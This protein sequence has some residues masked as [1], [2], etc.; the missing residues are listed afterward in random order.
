[1]RTIG[2]V[3]AATLA[4]GGAAAQA[5]P[6]VTA[7]GRL[8]F[9][10]DVQLS[11]DGKHFAG[12]QSLGG[13]PAAVIYAI[14]S[15]AEPQVFASDNWTVASV[16]WVKN[17]RVVMFT[18]T[19]KTIPFGEDPN[20]YTWY[21][22]LSLQVGSADWVQLFGR[23]NDSTSANSSTAVI[24]DKD[25]ADPDTIY[26]PLWTR[27]HNDRTDND[28][29]LRH[30][31]GYR[32]YRLS[33]YRV[34]VHTG[35]AKLVSD[36]SLFPSY[37]LTDGQGGI[38]GRVEQTRTPLVD[39]LSLYRDGSFT[40]VRDFDARADAG[41]NV[42]G[43]TFDGKALAVAEVNAAGRDVLGTLDRSSGAS[44]TPLYS[45]PVYD[46][47]F[48]MG[49]DW[50]GRV[51]GAAVMRDRLE[52]VYFDPVHQAVQSAV[53][54]LFPD[55]DAHPISMT[56]DGA[57]A[58]V[59]VES[60]DQPRTYYLYDVA[61]HTTQKLASEYPDLR[62]RDLGQVQ[63]YPYKAR[64]GLEIPAYLTLPPGRAGKNLPLVVMP[65]GGP[66]ARDGV[67]FDWWAQFLANRGYAV[68]QPNFRGSKGYGRAFNAAGFHQWGLKM[69]DDISDGVKRL[70]ADGVVDGK[71]VCIVGASYGGYA[72]LAGA[73]FTPDLYACAVSIAGPSDLARMLRAERSAYGD[74]S[75][76][77]SFWHSRIGD[78]SADAARLDA[79]SPALHADAVRVPVLLMHGKLDTTVPFAQSEEERDALQRAGKRVELVTFE[80]D[81]HYLN[82]AETRIQMLTALEAF[83]K[84]NIGG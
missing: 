11:P 36:G 63:P 9:V 56:L 69:Q 45:D 54:H 4:V 31:G 13:K 30:E 71:R 14:D 42:F 80:G 76:T 8:P 5:L 83:L 40:H 64:D 65:H 35:T 59:A 61:G 25:I 21:R 50:T 17:D 47:A 82:L 43:L 24:V 51:I 1:M 77:V 75:Q 37:W 72:A 48:A 70:I 68:F 39:H 16:R 15:T 20:L 29:S 62:P 67:R 28:P 46:V 78:E 74:N 58:I 27:P 79:T 12:I 7:F 41:A 34:D 26:M 44:G 33:L 84:A 22:A 52:Y 23:N 32:D 2:I 18:K 6:P 10:T 19:S 55:Q 81:D 66:D 60:P 73:T 57:K 53:A 3:L 38:V 49:D